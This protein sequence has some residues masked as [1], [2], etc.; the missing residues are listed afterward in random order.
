[1]SR[2]TRNGRSWRAF[3]NIFEKMLVPVV[4]A[5]AFYDNREICKERGKKTIRL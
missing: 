3:S 1:M 5:A 4:V 2:F